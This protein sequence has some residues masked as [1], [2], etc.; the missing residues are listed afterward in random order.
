[1]KTRN[2]ILGLTG[3]AALLV[4]ASFAGAALIGRWDFESEPSPWNDISGN[5]Y[6]ATVVGSVVRDTA[7]VR[8]GAASAKLDWGYL[9][10]PNMT[11]N[12]GGQA[13]TLNL[14]VK[15]FHAPVNDTDTGIES[16]GD[17]E[18]VRPYPAS[19]YPWTD[20]KGYFS[21]FRGADRVS[22]VAL[23]LDTTQWHMLTITTAPG[24][25]NYNIYE[26]GSLIYSGVNGDF[27]LLTNPL[28]GASRR[29]DGMPAY[30]SSLYFDD[31]RLYNEALSPGQIRAL[32]PEPAS[33]MVLAVAGLGL[34]RRRLAGRTA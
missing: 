7:T 34:L 12:F 29:D 8:Q 13:A 17:W 27:H 2:S 31:V 9:S 33:L 5:G 22:S 21:T 6:H 28:L 11:A 23:G 18:H 4:T 14:W 20:G 26:N 19:H 15:L 32:V 1:M 25:G 16:T 24:A 3:V 30:F 10:L